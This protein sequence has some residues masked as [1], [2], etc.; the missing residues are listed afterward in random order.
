MSSIP[1]VVRLNQ[2]VSERLTPLKPI[3]IQSAQC[4]IHPLRANC[5][6]IV[7]YSDVTE[8]K[9]INHITIL[10]SIYQNYDRRP[11]YKCLLDPA[12]EIDERGEYLNASELYAYVH[13]QP[14]DDEEVFY[15]IDEA[16]ERSMATLK[17]TIKAI[18]DCFDVC[19]DKY[20]LMVDELQIDVV[21]SIFRTVLLPQR[22][23]FIYQTENAPTNN[24]VQIFSVPQTVESLD[25]H[26]IYKSFLLYNTILT[27]MLKQKNPFNNNKKNISVVFRNLG[28]CPNNKDRVKCCDLNYGGNPPGHVMCPPR[29]MVRRIF[30]YS[31][32]AKTPNN[33]R[34]YFELITTPPINRRMYEAD[35]RVNFNYSTGMLIILDWYNF[36]E[37]F[38]AYFGIS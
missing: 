32:W 27:M 21:Y 5:R 14:I 33:Y 1:S 6:A 22:M 8:N 23:L 25:S 30:H 26:I 7:R 37:E 34:R 24:D 18:M 20:I 13:L 2:C 19:R 29:E 15:G 16:G 9:F 4:P 28:K 38:R 12:F 35:G 36:I 3:K 31:K 17:T 11:Y 10:E